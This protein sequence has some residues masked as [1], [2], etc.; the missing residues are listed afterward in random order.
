[1]QRFLLYPFRVWRLAMNAF[2][3]SG[4]LRLVCLLRNVNDFLVKLMV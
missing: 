3:A 4:S 2:T 1:M